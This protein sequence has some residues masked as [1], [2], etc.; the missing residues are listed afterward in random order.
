ML[1]HSDPHF[2]LNS[3]GTARQILGWIPTRA[4][5]IIIISFPRSNN[6]TKPGVEFRHSTRN[7]FRFFQKVRKGSVLTL[8]ISR[9]P[10]PTL[11][12]YDTV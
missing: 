1:R 7:P 10:Q 12:I 8:K 2:L 5:E 4:N 9:F 11:Y 3:G 6:E